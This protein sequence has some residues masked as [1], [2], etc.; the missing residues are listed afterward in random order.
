MSKHYIRID[1]ENKII[2]GFSSDF[3]N[4]LPTDICINENG[5]RQFELLGE[6]NPSL[7]D[8]YGCHLFR[9]DNITT[10][11]DVEVIEDASDEVVV[12]ENVDTSN[13]SL[14]DKDAVLEDVDVKVEKT[15]KATA[16]G[17]KTVTHTTYFVRRSTEEELEEE[18]NSKPLPKPTP[19]EEIKELKEQVS[20]L[21]D[22]LLEMSEIV[23][24][25]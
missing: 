19:E 21:T 9:Y 2:Y 7:T 12:T 23:Y 6:I 17:T 22:C 14:E 25:E 11:E 20:M 4:P 16:K 13:V 1:E 8:N 18:R 5:G 3:E 10:S 15:I 24:G